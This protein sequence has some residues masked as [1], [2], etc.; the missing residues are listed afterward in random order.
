MHANGRMKLVVNDPRRGLFRVNRAV[1]VSPEI[2]ELERRNVFDHSWLY[3]GH[4]SEVRKPGDFIARD[5]GGRPLILCHGSD[6]ELRVLI[7]SCTH[8]G[9][10]LCR[11]PAGNA[12]TFQCFYHA[13]T[14]NNHGELVGVP[15]AGGYGGA[16]RKEQLGLKSPARITNYRGMVFASFDPAI[17]DFV[18]YLAGAKEVLDTILDQAEDG[19]EIAAGTQ[20]YSFRANWKLLVENSIDGYHLRSTHHTYLEYLRS[21]GADLG[22]RPFRGHA[23]ALGNGHGVIEHSGPMGRPCALWEPRWGEE[24]KR[25]IA[26]LRARLVERFGEQRAERIAEW[27]RNLLIYPNL[28]VN[29]IMSLTVRTFYP[30]TPGYLEVSAWAMMPRSESPRWRAL[31]LDNFLTFLGPGGFATPDDLAALDSCQLGF[32]G[33]KEAQWSD[34]SRGMNRDSDATDEEQ[35]RSFWRRWS[36]QIEGGSTARRRAVA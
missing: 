17:E 16:F 6:G 30:I 15:D 2:L 14:F 11:E 22:G 10:Q 26:A 21:V 1:F 35:M 13:W 28:I 25:E 8:R 5:V 18:D 27:N 36:E 4:E 9:A 7:N 24:V 33:F 23:R 3:V 32:R 20:S 31:R 12:R 19:M 29:D 34:I